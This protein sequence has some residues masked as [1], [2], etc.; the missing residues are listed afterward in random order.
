MKRTVILTAIVAAGLA[1]AA[2]AQFPPVGDAQKVKDNLYIIPGEGGNTAVFVTANGVVLVDTS[3][4][5]TGRRS[6]ER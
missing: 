6:S 2:A 1:V 5:R 4:P 3:W